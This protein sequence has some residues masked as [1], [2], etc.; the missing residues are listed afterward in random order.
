MTA[1]LW[2]ALIPYAGVLVFGFHCELDKRELELCIGTPKKRGG[3]WAPPLF[4]HYRTTN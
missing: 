2:N 4:T 3:A 1:T